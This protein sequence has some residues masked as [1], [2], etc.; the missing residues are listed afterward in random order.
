MRARLTIEAG[1]G[2]PAAYDLS[3]EGSNT[4]GRHQ[5]NSIVLLDEH[6]S[7]RHAE[8]VFEDG[9]WLLRETD[10]PRNGTKVNGERIRQHAVLQNGYEIRIGDTRLRFSCSITQTLRMSAR[11]ESKLTPIGTT[12]PH[13]VKLL[14][15]PLQENEL[16]ALLTFIDQSIEEA[17]PR[18]LIGHALALIHAQTSAC[19]TGFLSLDPD[20]PLPKVVL[21]ELAH[22]DFHLSQQLTKRVQRDGRSVWLGGEINRINPSDSLLPFTDALC[23]PLRVSDSPLGALHVYKS[24]EGFTEREKCFCEVLAGYLA[25]SL[26]VLRTRR[27]LEAENTRL[28][29]RVSGDQLVG[30]SPAMQQLRQLIA[31]AAVRSSTVLIRGESGV[32][33][34]LVALALHRQS[35]RREEPLVVVNCA[36]ITSTMPEAELFGHCKGAYTGA[37][38]DRPGL[39]RQADEGTLF[40]DEVGELTLECQAKLL[41]VIEG[42]GFRPVG[43][44][45]EVKVDVRIIAATNRNLEKEVSAGK[46]RKD[47]FFRLQGI[48]I[49]VPPLREHAED[50]P[51]LVQFFL[52]N[53]ALEC[54]RQVKMTDAA[55]QRLQQYPWPG[56]VRQLR[57]VLECAVFMSDQ[58]TLEADD[59]RL[60]AE[61]SESPAPPL[62]L[63]QLETWAIK[64][65]LKQTEGNITQAAKLLG[66]VRETLS[67]KIKKFGITREDE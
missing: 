34:E 13:A 57:S 11:D 36:A 17:D 42:K 15:A 37:D 9:Q 35:N 4:L 39:F 27:T 31:K 48:P 30:D 67:T 44:D 64:H 66:I 65:A 32:G 54:R 59:L 51:V 33:K 23:V 16:N 43:V 45:D 14:Q 18:R 21:P 1:E 2:A 20:D 8:I 58:E 41:R 40:L 22:V 52:D 5:S 49:E 60:P 56:N 10:S 47:L 28:R 62:D 12:M 7:R 50:I 24:S 29:V 26:H 53:L 19:V 25:K 38:R 61:L 46:F 6:A 63:A 3:T 55:L